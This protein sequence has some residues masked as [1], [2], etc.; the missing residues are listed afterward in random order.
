LLVFVPWHSF[1]PS[2]HEWDGDL[3]TILLTWLWDYFET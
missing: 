3:R 2:H 1:A